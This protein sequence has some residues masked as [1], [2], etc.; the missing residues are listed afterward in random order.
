LLSKRPLGWLQVAILAGLSLAIAAGSNPGNVTSAPFLI[1]AII[2]SAEYT[3]DARALLVGAPILVIFYSA[4]LLFGYHSFTNDWLLSTAASLVLVLLLL[5]LYGG[6]YYRHWMQH[7]RESE[8]LESRVKERTA[9]LERALGERVVMLQEIHHRVKNNLQIV[10]SLLQLEA[11]RLPEDDAVRRPMETSIQR[12]HA[13]ALVH[14]TLYQTEEFKLVDLGNYTQELVS[15]ISGAIEAKIRYFPPEDS[16]IEVSLDFAIPFGL[17]LNELISNAAEHAFEASGT[18]TIEVHLSCT[19][20]VDLVVED[21]GV[22]IS[23]RDSLGEGN[24]LGLSLV[25][26][27][28]RQIN[29]DINLESSP[30]TRWHLTIPAGETNPAISGQA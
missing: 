16:R 10:A 17:L 5:V 1:L 12:I 4:A 30:G 15:A 7:R 24:S 21:N 11:N 19:S 2:L 25:H 3:K 23:I 14:E 22:G 28:V 27:L 26:A 8:L 6:I 13:M 9:E 20:S 29:G 18:G